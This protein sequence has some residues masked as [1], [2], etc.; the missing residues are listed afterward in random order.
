MNRDI[1]E[2]WE[3]KP[4]VQ[5]ASA[6]V[7]QGGPRAGAPSPVHRQPRLRPHQPQPVN[8]EGTV[9]HGG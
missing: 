1:T 7:P 6:P 9:F 3:G 4:S 2:S 5:S 8:D